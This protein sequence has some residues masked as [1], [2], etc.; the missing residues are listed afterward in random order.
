M[1]YY[2]NWKAAERDFKQALQ[3]NP[4][5]AL[6]HL[7]YSFLLTVTERNEEAISE[8]KRAQ[9]LDPLSFYI[10]GNAGLIFIYGGYYDKAIEIAQMTITMNPNFFYSYHLLGLAYS[11][12]SMNNEAVAGF[13]K[14]VDLSGGNPY[15][16]AALAVH[17]YEIG[18]Q[19]ETEKLYVSLKKRSEDEY[20]PPICFYWI[21][22]VRGDQD[23]SFEWLKRACNEHDSYLPWFRVAPIERFRIP[24]EPRFNE[25]LKKAGLEK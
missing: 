1:N 25:L 7:Y 20:V 5:S 15:L 8:V 19:D 2:W 11:A 3:I 9:E 23:Q 17:Y 12:K 13:E 24:D 18:K 4:N 14:A 16:M 10:N 22:K 6:I 21:H